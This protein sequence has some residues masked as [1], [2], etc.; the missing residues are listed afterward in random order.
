MTSTSWAWNHG[1]KSLFTAER[2][3]LA[4]KV[5]IRMAALRG[6]A[7]MIRAAPPGC[8]STLAPPA[9]TNALRQARTHLLSAYDAPGTARLVHCDTIFHSQRVSFRLGVLGGPRR[10]NHHLERTMLVRTGVFASVLVALGLALPT[11]AQGGDQLRSLQLSTAD[12]ASITAPIHYDED[13]AMLARLKAEEAQLTAI[14]AAFPPLFAQAYEQYPQ[15][16]KGVLE[17]IAYSQSRWLP[18]KADAG[19]GENHHHMPTAHGVMGL[20]GGEG[21]TDQLA[22]ASGL[23][24]VPAEVIAR[25]DRYNILAAAALLAREI[26]AERGNRRSSK[27]APD[28]ED[29]VPALV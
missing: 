24:G 2:M 21:F 1:K 14:R 29:I 7:S 16:P 9:A 18:L 12:A 5:M 3:P 26:D 6:K 10:T 22:Q 13:P 25:D 15:I 8:R 17:A 23:L 27:A 20:Y 11:A 28:A 19:H 4:L